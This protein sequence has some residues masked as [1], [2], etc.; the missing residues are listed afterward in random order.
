MPPPPA[1][2]DGR[3]GAKPDPIPPTVEWRNGRVRLIDQR[4]LPEELVFIEVAT[5][6]ELCAAI[7]S[8][9]IRGA[10]ALGVAGAMG[11]AL[12]AQLRQDV[13]AAAP[14]SWSPPA[15]LQST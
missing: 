12:A 8:L 9:A 4:R 5:V 6:D 2:A 1:A 7:S 11:V 10:P 13:D 14:A 3:T 15:R